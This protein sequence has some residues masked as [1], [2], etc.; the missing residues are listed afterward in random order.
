MKHRNDQSSSVKSNISKNSRRPIKSADTHAQPNS[1]REST[2]NRPM[3]DLA[4]EIKKTLEETNF[5]ISKVRALFDKLSQLEPKDLEP[6]SWWPRTYSF[7]EKIAIVKDKCRSKAL[8]CDD[9]EKE[10]K[11]LLTIFNNHRDELLE[12][13]MLNKSLKLPKNR[14]ELDSLYLKIC[15][16]DMPTKLKHAIV[17]EVGPKT[18]E[19]VLLAI[20]AQVA[21]EIPATAVP[22][23][24][25]LVLLAIPAQAAPET[26]ASVVPE[27]HEPVL[28]TIPAQ[29]A[30]ETPANFVPASSVVPT[31]LDPNIAMP[32]EP[33]L[34]EIAIDQL[35]KAHDLTA[36]KHRR[37]QEAIAKKQQQFQGAISKLDCRFENYSMALESALDQQEQTLE[38]IFVSADRLEKRLAATQEKFKANLAQ[39]ERE[40]KKHF[41]GAFSPLLSHWLKTEGTREDVLACMLQ[42]NLFPVAGMPGET[43]VPKYKDFEQELQSRDAYKEGQTYVIC[44]TG[45][46]STEYVILPAKVS[47]VHQPLT[48]FDLTKV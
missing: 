8:K 14:Q 46:R 35:R 10:K 18:P 36:E 40:V 7:T 23:P 11:H 3:T 31:T 12:G 22:E 44:E 6:F 34:A 26:P 32:P 38:R 15:T 33:D 45:W 9:L 19:P 42:M 43:I 16:V 30:P 41:I 29:G 27:T 39:A 13:L 5:D 37:R 20:P 47:A 48:S 25:E 28:L 2:Y 1:K 4:R 21:P 17:T 24:P